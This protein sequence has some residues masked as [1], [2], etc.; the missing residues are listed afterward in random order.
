MN[1]K[2]I[3]I[4]DNVPTLSDLKEH[5]YIP[6]EKTTWFVG[7][8]KE[9][10]NRM[11]KFLGQKTRVTTFEKPKTDPTSLE[12]DTTALSPYMSRG[13][14]SVRLLHSRL[15]EI[16]SDDPSSTKPPVSLEGQLYWREL[17]YLIGYTTPNFDQMVDNPICMQIPWR[18]GEDAQ[19]L[20]DKW[21]MGQTGYPAVD[22]T[23]NQLR[24]DGWIHHLSRHLAACFLTRGDLWVH[25]EMGRGIFEKYLL[26]A[27]YSINNFQWHWLSCSAFFR[28]YFRCYGPTTFYKKIDSNGEYIR[29][30]LPLLHQFPDQYI[31]AP[32]EAPKHVQEASGCMVGKDYPKPMVDHIIASKD[33]MLKM[34]IA[35]A[36][37]EEDAKIQKMV[38]SLVTRLETVPPTIIKTTTEP[39]K[40]TQ[41]QT[42]QKVE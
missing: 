39:T 29:K 34:K 8:E 13:S 22:A 2:Q 35:Y 25:W 3:E 32:W 18:E 42:E 6:E 33:N 28:Q 36:K 20:L 27:D 24:N 1:F 31:Y 37:A 40:K 17:S 16:T 4:F 7:G 41:V 38:E 30:H 10:M 26:D 19:A 23:M 9:G 5:G 12:P 14:V 21:E 11:E 15:K